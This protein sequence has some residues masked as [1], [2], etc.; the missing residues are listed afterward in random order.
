MT[1]L[2]VALL[3]LV[4]AVQWL[5]IWLLWS[6]LQAM[7]SI[8]R[9]LRVWDQPE[10]LATPAPEPGTTWVTSEREQ[11]RAE[12]LLTEESHQ[13]ATAPSRPGSKKRMHRSVRIPD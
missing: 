6:H 3:S 8:Q 2:L 5:T 10:H 13:R 9:A 4:M 12:Q 7:Q 1:W 11:A